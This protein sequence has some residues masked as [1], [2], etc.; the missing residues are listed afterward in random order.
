[1]NKK[2]LMLLVMVFTCSTM[3]ACTGFKTATNK[4]ATS[5]TVIEEPIKVP[6]ALSSAIEEKPEDN[7]AELKNQ[8]YEALKGYTEADF[9]D[10]EYFDI[11]AFAKQAGCTCVLSSNLDEIVIRPVGYNDTE[12]FKVVI[13]ISPATRMVSGDTIMLGKIGDDDWSET[14]NHYSATDFTTSMMIDSYGVQIGF[15]ELDYL[16]REIRLLTAPDNK[17]NE[18]NSEIDAEIQSYYDIGEETIQG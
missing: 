10:G 8:S 5:V 11:A 17:F 18:I 14:E 4:Q 6:A 7:T 3:I 13:K 2:L 9:Y 16:W 12:A 15:D 1:M